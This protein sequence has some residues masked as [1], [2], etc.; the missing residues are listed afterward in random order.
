MTH[1]RN[2]RPM[3]ASPR[4]GAKTRKGT[5]CQ[6]PALSGKTRCRM[7]GGATGSGAPKGNQN[8]LKHGLYTKEAL[9][10]RKHVRQLLRNGKELIEK[11]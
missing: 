7:H 4:C 9:A 5:P 8:A 2:T 6:A 3:R 11:F 1:Q 10:L